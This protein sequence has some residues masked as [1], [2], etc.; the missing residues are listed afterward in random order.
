MSVFQICMTSGVALMS[1]GR[2]AVI[3]YTMP[4]WAA[5]FAVFLLNE[6]VGWSHVAG[7]CLGVAG[8]TLLLSQ[9]LYDLAN[10]PIGPGLTLVA[11]IAF[12]LGT[13]WLERRIGNVDLTPIVGW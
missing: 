12:S 10:A 9:D 5:F 1:P 8:L 7:L 11:T 6:T 2:T 3:I 13:R 4:I